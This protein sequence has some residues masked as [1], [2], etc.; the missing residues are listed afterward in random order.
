MIIKNSKELFY[1]NGYLSSGCNLLIAFYRASPEISPKLII[2]FDQLIIVLWYY[3]S[4]NYDSIHLLAFLQSHSS[5]F[6]HVPIVRL[7]FC[8]YSKDQ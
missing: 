3:S 5:T 6:D 4:N 1:H 8:Y 7:H 2:S